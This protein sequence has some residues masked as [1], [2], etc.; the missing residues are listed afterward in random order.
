MKS[1]LCLFAVGTLLAAPALLQGKIVRDVEKTFTVQPGGNFKA[2]TQ[3]GDIVIQTADTNEVRI[4][5]RQTIHASSEQEADELL[6]HLSLTFQQDGNNVT[7]EAKYEKRSG[8][9][10]FK[11]WP[12]VQVGFNVTVP[13]KFNVR[14][15]AGTSRWPA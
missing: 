2:T 6:T 9:S 1:L 11:N 7:V 15:P 13:R 12:P 3:G 5:A 10:W 8:G 14:P 4:V